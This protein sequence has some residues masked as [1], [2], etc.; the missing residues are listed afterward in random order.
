MTHIS[1]TPNV[2]SYTDISDF[3]L[4]SFVATYSS[5]LTIQDTQNL[6]IKMKG[7]TTG[8]TA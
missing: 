5:F 3:S 4:I 7:N 6:T 8:I 1:Q 2:N